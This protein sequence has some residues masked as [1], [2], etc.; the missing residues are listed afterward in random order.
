MKQIYSNY[1]NLDQE[2]WK[3]LFERQVE[4]LQDKSC[5]QYLQ[6]LE[7]LSPVLNAKA[8]P[9]F[10]ELNQFL[11]A[12]CGWNVEVVKGLIPVDEF[13]QLLS[14]QKFC[15]STWLRRMNQLDY[16]E[17]PD[18]FHDIFGHIPLF[19]L[20]D[21]ARFMKTFGEIGIKF[22]ENKEIVTAL[23]RVYWYTIEFGLLKEAG[24]KKLFGA[25]IMSSYGESKHIAED[26]IEVRPY[27]LEKIMQT[28]FTT[29]EIQSFYFEINS[30]KELV[31]DLERYQ[32]KLSQRT[33]AS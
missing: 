7:Q 20:P 23:Q 25:G 17:E 14:N 28:D 22:R 18:M 2:V 26:E 4:N 13:F 16:L 15:S 12:N 31:D 33:V 19:V 8:I 11:S 5:M 29:T 1:T 30:F 9:D 3:I 21:Y 10:N 32:N 6:C 24:Q 27:D